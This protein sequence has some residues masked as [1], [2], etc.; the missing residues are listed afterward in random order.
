VTSRVR[1]H[2]RQ[3]SYVTSRQKFKIIVVDFSYRADN[4]FTTILLRDRVIWLKGGAKIKISI[5]FV[6]VSAVP[7]QRFMENQVR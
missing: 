1:W 6:C 3:I 7:E 2:T 4:V 5:Q